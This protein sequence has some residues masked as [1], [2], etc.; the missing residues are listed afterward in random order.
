[1]QGMIYIHESELRVHGN[2][3]SSNCVI[4]SRW[5]LQVAD[6][7]LLSVRRYQ[8][9]DLYAAYKSAFTR[10]VHIHIRAK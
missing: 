5:T 9:D 1:M 6:F 10:I 8:T 4:N 7:G 2:L 3:K